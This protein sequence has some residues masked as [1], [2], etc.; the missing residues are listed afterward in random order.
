LISCL[1][2]ARLLIGGVGAM[3]L[4]LAGGAV[5][6]TKFPSSVHVSW[7]RDATG[8]RIVTLRPAS[9]SLH[10][11]S[12]RLAV[13]WQPSIPALVPD[14]SYQTM[15]VPPTNANAYTLSLPLSW[16]VLG[17]MAYFA[18]VLRRRSVR[19]GR[20]AR[21]QCINCG[22]QLDPTEPNPVCPECGSMCNSGH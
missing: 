13:G 18:V 10:S 21:C 7:A 9:E 8:L 6:V 5:H 12:E 20:A 1:V 16:P 3:E 11:Q 17:L 19:A 22:Y 15:G 2:D 14:W 4:S